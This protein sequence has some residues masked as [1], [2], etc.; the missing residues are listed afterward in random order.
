MELREGENILRVYHHHPTPFI[1][2]VIK[3]AISF[4]PFYLF[5]YLFQDSMS[6]KWAIIIN[7][8]FFVAF[9][10][11]ILYLTFIYWLD[12]LIVTNQRIVFKDYKFLTLS[13]ESQTF[14]RDIQD[15]ISRE[16]GILSYF[17]IFDY[18]TIRMETSSSTSIVIFDNAPDP[19]GIRQYIFQLRKQ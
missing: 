16:K 13:E 3:A 14:I 6:A 7:V 18:G 1:W 11:V 8:I 9:T 19:E 10:L 2:M 4:S 15:I 5:I 17:R 12:K